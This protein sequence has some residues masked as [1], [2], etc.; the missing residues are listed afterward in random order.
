M[1]HWVVCCFV[2][3][4]ALFSCREDRFDFDNSPRVTRAPGFVYL[5]GDH[6]MVD[7][8]VW[9]PLMM[10]YKIDWYH[11]GHDITIG[12]ASY[13]EKTYD[14]Q[15][16]EEYPWQQIEN[17]F[18][19]MTSLGRCHD[20]SAGGINSIRVCLDVVNHNE[21][22]YFYGSSDHPLH[23]IKDSTAIFNSIENTLV[24]RAK[25]CG[26]R[27]MLLIPRPLDEELMAFAAALLRRFANEPT[28]WAYDF[29]NEP[30]YFDPVEKRSKT[31]AYR[32]VNKWRELMNKYAPHQLFTIGFSEPL[33]VFE[34]DPSILPVDFVEVHTYHP[35]RIGAEMYWYGRY[36]GRPWMIG[37]TALPSEN[38]SVP[39]EWQKI[40]AKEAC[41][42]A[43]DNGACGFG[44]WEFQEYIGGVNF[45]AQ[46]TGVFNHEGFTIGGWTEEGKFETESVPTLEGR[47]YNFAM[48]GQRKPVC[49]IFAELSK[50]K[51]HKA[52]M[53]TNYY[54]M[55]GYHNIAVGGKVTD[56]NGNPIEGAVV[57]GW[58]EDWSVGANTYSRED[59]SFWLITN[60][61]CTHFEVSAPGM[62]VTEFDRR[63]SLGGMKP[64]ALPDRTLEYQGISYVPFLKSDTSMFTFK[65]EMFDKAQHWFDNAVGTVKLKKLNR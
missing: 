44:W 34:W 36:V 32:V 64:E 53:P 45:E 52:K 41:Q 10:N 57:R 13:Y 18:H 27:L 30:L 63:Y 38:D 15:G 55:V 51:P 61:V 65:A 24:L 9:F 19:L 58:N 26:L 49:D 46:Y 4:L 6:F 42:L 3:L 23:L 16:Q 5:E 7:D 39:Y 11:I 2:L 12:P 50:L 14:M 35:L 62:S 59:G 43:I 54:N 37:E 31:D 60:D 29:M 22:G 17:H 20:S 33:E 56:E 21:N 40:F 1:K 48:K 28:I 47:R 25:N 8:S